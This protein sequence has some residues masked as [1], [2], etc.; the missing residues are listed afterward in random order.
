MIWFSLSLATAFCVGTA[1]VLSKKALRTSP[2]PA[3]AMA[4]MG[5]AAAFL[6]PLLLFASAPSDPNGFWRAVLLAVPLEVI[7]VFA[8]QTALRS[9]P[10]SLSV[11]YLAFTP[12]FLLLT[13]WL[14]L[15]ERAT[16][17]GGAGIL[18]V[19]AGAFVLPWEKGRQTGRRLL[20]PFEKGALLMLLVA[21][22]FSITSALAKKAVIASSPFFFSGIYF[23][24]VAICLLPFQWR[25]RSW[26]GDL[27]RQPG[28]FAAIGFLEAL[29]L[30]LQFHAFLM[31]EVAYALSIKRLSLLLAVVYGHLV[32][33]EGDLPSRAGGAVLMLAGAA[34]ITLK[35]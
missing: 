32:F 24:L 7:A 17:G 4:R 29:G 22:L 16:A 30:V 20:P 13:G 8:Y 25:S 6:L 2:I 12:V 31:V 18:L 14:F 3:V 15:G 23:L 9:S 5:W 19:T 21:F 28:V 1:D 27:V 33:K 34:L 35:G 26:A 10:L 11:P